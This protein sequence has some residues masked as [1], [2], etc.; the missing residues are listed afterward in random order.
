M[1]PLS[2]TLGTSTPSFVRCFVLVRVRKSVLL[3]PLPRIKF[4]NF[5][6]FVCCGNSL[7]KCPTEFNCPIDGHPRCMPMNRNIGK[8]CTRQQNWPISRHFSVICELVTVPTDRKEAALV[9]LKFEVFCLVLESPAGASACA[10]PKKLAHVVRM[11]RALQLFYCP[12]TF[13]AIQNC[14]LQQLTR[15]ATKFL[16]MNDLK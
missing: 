3:F 7:N 13:F 9:H 6:V 4:T 15:E 11:A 2:L 8:F 16:P 14:Y 12:V 1:V 10:G 5:S